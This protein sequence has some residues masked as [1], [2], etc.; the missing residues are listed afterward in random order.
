MLYTIYNDIHKF[1]PHEMKVDYI[2]GETVIYNGDIVDIGACAYSELPEANRFLLDLIE[3]AKCNFTSGNHE[4]MME[5]P[6]VVKDK[7]LFIHGDLVFKD[8]TAARNFRW[9]REGSGW[10]RR[11]YVR[12]GSYLRHFLK[13]NNGISDNDMTEAIEWAKRHKCHTIV[14]GHKHPKEILKR[15]KDGVTLIILPRGI[16]IINI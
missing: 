16:N 3:K 12:A 14:C 10:F 11:L 5:Y 4:K 7:I 2:F 9:G 13:K 8:I 6:F 1:A 15:T